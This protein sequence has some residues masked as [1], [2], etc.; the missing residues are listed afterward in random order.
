MRKAYRRLGRREFL[1]TKGI[2]RKTEAVRVSLSRL[3]KSGRLSRTLDGKFAVPSSNGNGASP[4]AEAPTPSG[5][6]LGVEAPRLTGLG[7]SRD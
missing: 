5:D 3:E 1:M 7:D 2:V 6:A 4:H